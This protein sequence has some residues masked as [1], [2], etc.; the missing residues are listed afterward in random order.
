MNHVTGGCD[1][2]WTQMDE[3][4]AVAVAT[5]A[6][7]A[8]VFVVFIWLPSGKRFH[9]SLWHEHRVKQTEMVFY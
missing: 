7:V 2:R 1:Q 9:R 6:T 4:N 5:T 3:D 8:F